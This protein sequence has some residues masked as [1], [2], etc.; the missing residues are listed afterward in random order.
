LLR[1]LPVAVLRWC[2]E[3]GAGWLSRLFFSYV[4]S[5]VAKGRRKV[6][7]PE[8]LWDVAAADEAGLV[9]G[10]FKA[11]LEATHHPQRA[12]QVGCGADGAGA[13]WSAWA[14]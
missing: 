5:L 11:Q 3:E 7:M 1:C 14:T 10:A 13:G 2:P 12:P 9:W 8:D 4:D 6:L